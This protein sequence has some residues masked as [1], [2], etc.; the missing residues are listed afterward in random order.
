MKKVIS[1]IVLSLIATIMMA[2][3]TVVTGILVDATLQEGEPFATVRVFKAN[4][5]D[6]PVTMFLTD[7]NGK[8][9]Q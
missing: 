2:Q 7:E 5:K 4:K 9:S 1:T 8:F 6:K 3:K